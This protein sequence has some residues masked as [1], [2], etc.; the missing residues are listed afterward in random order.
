LDLRPVG[1]GSA[2]GFWFSNAA[3]GVLARCMTVLY[4]MPL[5]ERS[6][7]STFTELSS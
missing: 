7:F 4:F 1:F 5:A 3:T 6:A 2:I